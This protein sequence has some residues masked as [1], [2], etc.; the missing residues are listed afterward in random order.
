[1]FPVRIYSNSIA[2]S[3]EMRK[4]YQSCTEILHGLCVIEKGVQEL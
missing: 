1:M 2:K 3:M 4:L